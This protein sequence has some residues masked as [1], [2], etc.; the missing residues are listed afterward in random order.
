MAKKYRYICID[1]MPDEVQQANA[2]LNAAISNLHIKTQ[3]P[4]DF[5]SQVSEVAR[6]RKKKELDGL[7]LDL[8]IDQFGSPGVPPVDY[9]AQRLAGEL[10]SRMAEGRLSDFPIVL[11]SI[12]QKFARSYDKDLTSHDLFDLVIDKEEL[13]GN[14]QIRLGAQRLAALAKAFD[15]IAKQ[16]RT[17]SFWNDLLRNPH[18]SVLDTRVGQ[19]LGR[20]LKRTP[21]HAI[22]RYTLKSIVEMPGPLIDRSLLCARL[23]IEEASLSGTDLAAKLDKTAAYKGPFSDAW[24]RWWWSAVE[25]WWH[26]LGTNLAPMLSLTADERVKQLKDSGYKQVMTA[27]VIAKGYSPRFTTICQKL[28]QPIDPI[29][30]F[31]LAAA[32]YEPWQD[33]LYVSRKVALEPGRYRFDDS[34]LDPLELSRV[35]EARKKEKRPTH[36]R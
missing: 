32:D 8:R 21:I 17:M 30:G 2:R 18:P 28:R 26:T 14:D 11:W 4:K 22:A 3:A 13:H 25:K 35:R 36:A 6:L 29:D 15:L 5:K 12:S 19:T 27:E 23:G 31:V 7:I 33:R 34:Q 10:R 1:D 16:P 9:K 20:S 24:P